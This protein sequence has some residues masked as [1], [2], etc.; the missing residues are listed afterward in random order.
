MSSE[1]VSVAPYPYAFTDDFREAISQAAP[2]ERADVIGRIDRMLLNPIFNYRPLPQ[3]RNFHKSKKN[4]RWAVGGNRSSKSHSV[5]Q[6][7]IW[8]ATGTHPWKN[9]QAPN[10]GWYCTITWEMVG[11]ILWEKMERLFYGTDP[12]TGKL[13]TI[14][15]TPHRTI[16]RN[17]AKKVPDTVIIPI[18]RNGKYLGDSRIIFKAYEQGSDI[19]QGTERRYIANDEQFPESVFTEQISRI[20][21]GDPLDFF[22]AMTP[23]KPQPWLEE[24]LS[25]ELPPSWDLFEYPLDDNRISRGGFLPDAVIDAT[26]EEWPEE[27][28]P[29]RRYGKWASFIGA[30]FKTFNRAVHVVEED[31]ERLFFP[32]GYVPPTCTSIGGIDWG[33]N[34][35]F[36]FIWAT[37]IPHLDNEWYV[38]DEYYWDNKT[39]GVR[40]LKTHAEHI[41][42]KTKRWRASFTRSWADHDPQDRHEFSNYG[43][44]SLSAN[45]DVFAGIQTVQKLLHIRK[46]TGRP[47]LHI[48]KRCR[49]LIRQIATYQWQ[50]GTET[51]D[52]KEEPV[53]VEDHTVDALRYILHSEQILRPDP[54]PEDEWRKQQQ[55]ESVAIQQP[56]AQTRF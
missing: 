16:W 54:D 14:P 48:A 46:T 8:Y 44:P 47:R 33:G 17:R 27:M 42:D 24:R 11:S 9:V 2:Y 45:K 43:I 34:N 36:C 32:K 30:V 38:Y 39:R 53:K 1:Q 4:V 20:G 6:E 29:T 37:P 26:I 35:P 22:A 5:A 7:V 41:L 40:L 51:R 3:A 18:W 31:D 50:E 23:L 55:R 13:N 25:V 52:P 56:M 12:R 21:P 19:F 10:T 15:I 49:N 28:Q